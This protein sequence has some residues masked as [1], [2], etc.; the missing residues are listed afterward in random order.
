MSHMTLGERLRA[1]RHDDEGRLRVSAQELAEEMGWTCASQIT[2]RE[3]GQIA[4]T[5]AELLEICAGVAR[6]LERRREER[7]PA[8]VLDE[9]SMD[10]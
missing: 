10:R 5:E 1:F 6:I 9:S 3:K 8:D 7:T 4:M 2:R